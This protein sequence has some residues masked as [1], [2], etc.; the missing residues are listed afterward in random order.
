[1]YPGPRRSNVF[2]PTKPFPLIIRFLSNQLAQWS[3]LGITLLFACL[4]S[5]C[6][7]PLFSCRLT[8]FLR[9]QVDVCPAA[10]L[11][12]SG[13]RP[14]AI[15]GDEVC[16]VT[17]PNPWEAT[18]IPVARFSV[19]IVTLVLLV[20]FSH[21]TSASRARQTTPAPGSIPALCAQA[22]AGDSAASHR[23][24][25]FL[26]SHDS[27]DPSFTAALDCVRVRS[28][29]GN[30]DSQFLL[31]YLLEHGHGVTRDYVLAAQ[32][33]QLAAD[34]GHSFAQNNLAALYQH[35]LGVPRDPQKAFAL[36]LAAAQ[37]GNSASQT[38]LA[39]MYYSGDGVPRNLPEAAHWFLS[40]ANL[41]DPVAQHNLG[42]LYHRGEGVPVDLDA[43]SMWIRRSASQGLPSAETDLALLYE[44]GSGVPRDYFSAY[45]W[46]S[47]AITAGD[48]SGSAHRD[49]I[50][51][52][53][54][55]KQ[56]DEGAAMAASAS[57]ST[58]PR[59]DSLSLFPPH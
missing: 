42:V 47:R 54:T 13:S 33:Y 34:Q 29:H 19:R 27:A 7:A 31:A 37:R 22:D 58:P 26:L 21:F 51:R 40:A 6:P 39:S 17:N 30:A 59:S 15:H 36:Y 20:L 25:Q 16:A 12:V 9:A 53:L 11:T 38:N 46:Y 24:Q 32:T 3:Q 1:M 4:E 49:S 10:L 2:A 18:V 14:L 41:S 23:L 44:T 57:S 28:S 5:V 55:R 56:R 52:H 45:L 8:P 50:A 35:G 43:A 48:L